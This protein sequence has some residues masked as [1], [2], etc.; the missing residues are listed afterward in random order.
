MKCRVIQDLFQYKNSRTAVLLG[1][2]SSIARVTDEQ[3]EWIRTCDKWALNNWVYHPFIVPDF[4]AIETKWYGYDILK[5][6]LMEKKEAY[7]HTKFLFPRGK[8]IRM[9]NGVSL[10]LR[11]VVDKDLNRFEYAQVSRDAKRTSST[12]NADYIFN[13][14]SLTKS[15]NISVTSILELMWKFGYKRIVLFGI[16]LKDSLYFW[17]GGECEYGEV[18]HL[19]NKAH[20]N[21]D[22]KKPHNTYRIKDFFIDFNQR[23]MLPNNRQIFVGHT[24]TSLYPHIPLFTEGS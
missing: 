12:F 19:T 20:E 8:Q 1:S 5:R 3:W 24:D 9:R 4:Y 10:F 6:R 2:G 11:D 14:N 15:Y 22:P 23:W 18:H 13:S 17:S 16:D 21:K 7:R